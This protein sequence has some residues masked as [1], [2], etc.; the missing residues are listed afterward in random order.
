MKLED[1]LGLAVPVTYVLMLVVEK[2]APA[3]KFPP[4]RR[5]ALFGV[6]GFLLMGASA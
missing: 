1:A 6:V 3:R 2:L 4:I 5:W